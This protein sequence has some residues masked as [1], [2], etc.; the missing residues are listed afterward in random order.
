[1]MNVKDSLSKK[2]MGGSGGVF[3]YSPFSYFRSTKG[4]TLIELIIVIAIIATLAAAIFVAV[5]PARRLHESRNARRQSD[6][7]TIL[8]GV[9]KYHADNSVHYTDVANATQDL[10]KII[11]TLD[12]DDGL[13]LGQGTAAQACTLTTSGA[14]TQDCVDL[15]EIGGKYIGSVPT[16]PQTG[17]NTNTRY[18]LRRGSDNSITVGA[19]QEEGEGSGGVGAAPVIELKR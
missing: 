4:F 18:Y 17:T 1:M 15:T 9:M 12:N 16:D 14:G 10:Y 3:V 8:E 13:C 7:N 11:G 5:D 2:S 19:C 6:V